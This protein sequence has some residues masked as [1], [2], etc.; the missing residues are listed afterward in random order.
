MELN[1]LMVIFSQLH[2]KMDSIIEIGYCD[3]MRMALWAP[4][5]GV[6][7]FERYLSAIRSK[8]DHTDETWGLFNRFEISAEKRILSVQVSHGFVGLFN[9]LGENCV[10]F[11]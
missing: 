9:A 6:M 7:K 2:G 10:E 5:Q 4:N 11:R 3:I 1:L 8:L